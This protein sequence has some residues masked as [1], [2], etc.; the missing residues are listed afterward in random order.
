MKPWLIRKRHSGTGAAFTLV[1]MLV[2]IVIII[3]LFG[4]G[5]Q[6][7]LRAQRMAHSSNCMRQLQSIGSALNLHLVD[8]GAIMPEMAA[9]RDSKK[10]PSELELPTMDI[11][12]LEYM[13][14]DDSAF[15]CPADHE[16]YAKTGCS[17]F[18]NS[19]VN[20]QPTGALN[21]MGLTKNHSGI[22]LISDKENFHH[23]I[24][25]GVNILYA[26]GHVQKEL[27]F[28]IDAK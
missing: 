16:H 5:S 27:Q 4:I 7:F 14:D 15:H 28:I 21:F 20:G 19:L 23:H 2:T 18:W 6:A 11:V 1:E 22:P 13:N 10:P 3:V 26:D 17:Y 8:T 24:G 12:L 25:D 9:A